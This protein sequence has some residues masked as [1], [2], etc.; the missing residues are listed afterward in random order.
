MIL[1]RSPR[2]EL[3]GFLDVCTCDGVA[4]WAARLDRPDEIVDVLVFVDGR[5]VAKVRCDLPRQ[6]LAAAGIYGD[7]AHGF[8]HKFTPPLAANILVSVSVRFALTGVPMTNGEQW[9]GGRHPERQPAADVPS[10]ADAQP[11]APSVQ[12]APVAEKQSLYIGHADVISREGVSGWALQADQPD[13]AI[14]VIVFVN[15][16]RVA[17]V[18][19]DRPR[20]DLARQRAWSNASHGFRFA[21]AA[22]LPEELDLRIAVRFADTGEVLDGGEQE[23]PAATR[24]DR[25]APILVTAPG[26]SGTT[27]LMEILLGSDE[28]VVANCH[29]GRGQDAVVRCDRP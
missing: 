9:V 4:G 19:C 17:R 27:M 7:G 20:P 8:S 18:C 1:P 24:P 3:A 29:P 11:P 22:R 10:S 16:Q 28:V 21:F 5:E 15:G 6:D 14:D 12:P 26:R 13:A 25:L 2:S 23:I